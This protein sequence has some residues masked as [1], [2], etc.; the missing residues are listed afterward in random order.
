MGGCWVCNPFCGKCKPPVIRLQCPEC[1]K[2]YFPELSKEKQC[3]KCG[4]VLPEWIPPQ[5]I[6]CAYIEQMCAKPCGRYSVTPEDDVFRPCAFYTLPK[7][8]S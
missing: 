4:T 1:S 3:K 2:Y 7:K 8:V 6:W 5:A